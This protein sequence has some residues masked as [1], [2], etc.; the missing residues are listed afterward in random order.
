VNAAGHARTAGVV[1]A[2]AR[3]HVQVMSGRH[4]WKVRHI[5]GNPHVSVTVPIPERIPLL[6]MI[7]VPA[8]TFTFHGTARLVG[9]SNAHPDVVTAL[10]GG[11]ETARDM[12]VVEI[13]HEGDFV[14]YGIGMRVQ[15]CATPSSPAAKCR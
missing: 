4:E 5:E 1:I 12:T 8:A 13:A 10:T 6:P 15:R 11:L 9:P 3:P 7:K 2:T 14:T